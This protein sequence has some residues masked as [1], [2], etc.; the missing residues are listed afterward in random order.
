MTARQFKCETC[1]KT[2]EKLRYLKQ[3]KRTH[4]TRETVKKYDCNH[5]EKRFASNQSL[6]KH[7]KKK[8]PDPMKFEEVGIDSNQMKRKK[9]FKCEHC[10][11]FS[12]RNSNVMRHIETHFSNKLKTGRPKKPPSEW[13]AVTKRIYAKRSLDEFMTRLKE[14]HLEDRVKKLL[15]RDIERKTSDFF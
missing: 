15:K 14:N 10:N 4:F 9:V 8:H 6:G 11:Y 5:C 13:S 2:F 1:E 7:V 3:H 12:E